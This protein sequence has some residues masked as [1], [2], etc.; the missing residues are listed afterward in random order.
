[1]NWMKSIN[2]IVALSLST[3]IAGCS[4]APTYHRP[5]LIVPPTYKE[6]GK[7]LSAKP[8]QVIDHRPWWVM[9]HDSKLNQ[10]EQRVTLANQDLK[11]A[12]ARYQEARAIA[13]QA[14]AAYFPTVNGIG[15]ADRLKASRNV[16]VPIAVPVYNDTL[17]S[18]DLS[19]EVDVW[20]RVRNLVAAANSR[21]RASQADLAVV[22]LSL[23]A[24][25]ASDYFT[26]LSD[27]EA[28]RILDETVVAYQKALYLT[29]QRFKG[30]AVSV[31][32]VDQA[33][34][35]LDV[36]KTMAADTHLKRSQLEHAIAILLGEPPAT[37]TLFPTK[38]KI[39]QVTID[40]S[41]PSALLQQRP[42][43]AESEQ[44]VVA[45]NADIGVARAAYFPAIN[46]TA[47][48]GYESQSLSNL[49]KSP[50]LIW[51]LGPSALLTIFNSTSLP[52]VTQTIFDG[53][54]ISGLN[55][56]ACA[57]YF[58]TVANY[59][60]TVLIAFQEVEDSLTALHQLDIE[61]K[62]QSAATAAAERALQ[63]AMF[64]YKGGL[65]TYLD[66]VVL[67]NIALQNELSS[68]DVIN[69]RQLASVQLIK[70]FGGGWDDKQLSSC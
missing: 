9:Y 38:K 54:K 64:R 49:L 26:L 69:R 67:Q 40:P 42:D 53:G 17:V 66:V 23:H 65:V 1:M 20:G 11:A 45:A 56:Q 60:Q 27:D 10:L 15:N 34:T 43:V 47:G 32:D 46:L 59:R 33:Q 29:Q 6:K 70:A 41:Y 51:S 39:H 52:L 22:D 36:A 28:Q 3:I 57:H 7:W 44:L 61:N 19:Y 68:V 31:L 18:A 16:A 14:R 24:E 63:Q 12:A 4:L 30:G 50:S 37:F 2:V 8:K 35:Q 48:I 5:S 13:K 62:T 21:A 58:E 55:D 25:L